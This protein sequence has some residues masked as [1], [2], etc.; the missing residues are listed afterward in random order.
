MS[1]EL[2]C[3]VIPALGNIWGMLLI[4]F[5]NHVR[6]HQPKVAWYTVLFPDCHPSAHDGRRIATRQF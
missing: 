6:T 1:K 2:N 3:T 4:P 5:L